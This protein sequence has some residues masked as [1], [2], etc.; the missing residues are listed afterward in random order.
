MIHR[1]MNLFDVPNV[2][3][4]VDW[5]CMS[6]LSPWAQ[7]D[8]W[9]F[10]DLLIIGDGDC[11]PG[12]GCMALLK[13]RK[14]WKNLIFEG[15]HFQKTFRENDDVIGG[16]LRQFLEDEI[17]NIIFRDCAVTLESLNCFVKLWMQSKNTVLKKLTITFVTG[18]RCLTPVNLLKGLTPSRNRLA[19]S[20]EN[21][22]FK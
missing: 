18:K 2:Y 10:T 22:E 17:E 11:H 14:I 6:S 3:L 4:K 12:I 15:V 20:R 8:N 5:T 9:P 1:I 7:E 16:F 21:G 13:R 19:I